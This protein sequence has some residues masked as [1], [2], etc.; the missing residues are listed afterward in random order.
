MNAINGSHTIAS[1]V[2]LKNNLVLDGIGNV[3][4]T[5]DVDATN[6]VRLTIGDVKLLSIAC[7]SGRLCEAGLEQWTIQTCFTARARE[8]RDFILLEIHLPDLVWTSHRDLEHTTDELE[9]AGVDL[10][11]ERAAKV[12]A[13]ARTAALYGH[14]LA[15]A[16]IAFVV[17]SWVGLGL[18]RSAWINLDLIWAVALIGTL[19]WSGTTARGTSLQFYVLITLAVLAMAT[20]TV[21]LRR[22]A[23]IPVQTTYI[24][25][26]LAFFAEEAVQAV[27]ERGTPRAAEARRRASA[28]MSLSTARRRRHSVH[29]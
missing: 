2:V 17:Y 15:T 18:L 28:C 10:S 19:V 14:L 8:R 27:T 9:K 11:A 7:D 13:A 4:F 5:G 21:T 3:A 26:M 23:G 16:L 6:D 1:P 24:T 22:V 12:G 25:T 20:Q 29:T